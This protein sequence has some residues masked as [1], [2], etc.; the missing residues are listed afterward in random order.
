MEI[1][2]SNY[3]LSELKDARQS[4]DEYKYPNRVIELDQRIASQQGNRKEITEAPYQRYSTF[5]ARFVA[6]IIDGLAISGISFLFAYIIVQISESLNLLVDLFDLF[7]FVVYS[8]L[9]HGTFGQTIGKMITEVKVLDAKTEK[10]IGFRQ[11]VIR[12]SVPLLSS[13]FVASIILIFSTKDIN[14]SDSTLIYNSLMVFAVVSL[15]WHLLEIITMLFNAKR[16]AIHD[17]MAGTVVVNM[18]ASDEQE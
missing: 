2:Y 12:D 6:G 14:K 1:D 13:I 4:I 10:P 17:Y 8:I 9:M 7:L 15:S 18:Q 11:A 3:S 16:R 5:G